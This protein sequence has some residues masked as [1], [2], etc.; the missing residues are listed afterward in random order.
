MPLDRQTAKH[1]LHPYICTYKCTMN[2]KKTRKAYGSWTLMHILTIC[3]DSIIFLFVA[4][5]ICC[6][7]ILKTKSRVLHKKSLQQKQKHIIYSHFT[8]ACGDVAW[9]NFVE[10]RQVGA[11]RE[12]NS[13]LWVWQRI[14]LCPCRRIYYMLHTLNTFTSYKRSTPR[15]SCQCHFNV[16][17]TNCQLSEFYCFF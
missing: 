7:Y 5:E 3:S 16:N 4:S 2:S 10:R 8:A 15:A 1:A 11:N 6:F 14:C 12:F 17:T 9:T 13:Q